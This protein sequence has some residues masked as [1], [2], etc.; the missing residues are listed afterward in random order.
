MDPL[1]GPEQKSQK[2]SRVSARPDKHKQGAVLISGPVK[3]NYQDQLSVVGQFS[4]PACF[5]PVS[6]LQSL[7]TAD[8]TVRFPL[9]KTLPS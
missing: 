8:L 2:S 4:R 6:S 1:A 3:S 9:G 7:L 5:G